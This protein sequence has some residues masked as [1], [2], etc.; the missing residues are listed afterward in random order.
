MNKLHRPIAAALCALAATLG[1]TCLPGHA[2]EEHSAAAR[3]PPRSTKATQTAA[4]LRD[5]WLGHIFWVRNVALATLQRND[6]AAKAAEQQVVANAR[7]IAG[8][9]EPFY[10]TAAKDA[11]FN[12][13]AGHYAAVKACLVAIAAGDEA[14]QATATQALTANAEGI[15]AFLGKANPNLSKDAVAGLLLA[16]GGHHIQQIQD[17][18]AGR[19]D[20]EAKTWEDMKSHMYQVSDALTNALVKQFAGRF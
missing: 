2:H 7:A 11:L 15:A 17:L 13:L 1:A 20:A 3:Q 8:A 18:K 12:L 14:A 10:G 5:L 16:H 9:I 19:F 4:T 6:A